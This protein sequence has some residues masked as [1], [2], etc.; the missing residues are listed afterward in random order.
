M[1]QR[2]R[3]RTGALSLVPLFGLGLATPSLAGTGAGADFGVTVP[4]R[5]S[6]VQIGYSLNVRAF[7]EWT[8]GLMAVGVQG[9]VNYQTVGGEGL[10]RGLVGGRITVGPVVKAYA[11]AHA[12]V[13]GS[14]SQPS[15]T[16][17]FDLGVGFKTGPVRAGLYGRYNM[18]TRVEQ[19]NWVDA[20]ISA[21]IAF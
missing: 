17:A 15:F 16:T 14:G 9:L 20:G 13:G 5:D 2:R 1:T 3:F 11:A 18:L 6:D 8:F 21:E 4:I 10:T 7:H 12:G 19:L